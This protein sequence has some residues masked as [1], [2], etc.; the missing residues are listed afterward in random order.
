METLP[1]SKAIAVK[2]R[3]IA[4]EL[5]DFTYEEPVNGS[6]CLYRPTDLNPHGCIV[7]AALSR[8]GVS[9]DTLRS[10]DPKGSWDNVQ[11]WPTTVIDDWISAFQDAQDNG[12]SWGEA[13]VKADKDF[14]EN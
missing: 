2:M 1:K 4:K 8:L 13:L 14:P 7:G 10:L 5:P 11:I 6:G 12:A 9:K 3:E